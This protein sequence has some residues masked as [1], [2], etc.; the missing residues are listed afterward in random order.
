[1]TE[2]GPVGMEWKMD[3]RHR[4]EMVCSVPENVKARIRLRS[5]AT[6][7]VLDLDGKAIRSQSSPGWLE[8][9]LQPGKHTITF[10]NDVSEKG[11]RP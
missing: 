7:D 11:G 5:Q 1:V 6:T 8:A 3:H 9:I 2:F 10:R 4:P